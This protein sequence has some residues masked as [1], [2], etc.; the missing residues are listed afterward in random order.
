[1]STPRWRPI[2]TA[3]K[4]AQILLLYQGHDHLP[5]VCQGCWVSSPHEN[6]YLR[7]LRGEQSPD[8]SDTEG[9]WQIGYIATY[10]SYG[11]QISH[12]KADSFRVFPTHWQPLPKPPV[13][14]PRGYSRYG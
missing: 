6:V 8:E 1:M 12:W 7:V 10:G 3:P 14:L 13:R 4:D 2:S 5:F 11:Q 9:R